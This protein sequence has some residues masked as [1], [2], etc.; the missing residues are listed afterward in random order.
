LSPNVCPH[1]F[2]MFA[3]ADCRDVQPWV[4]GVLVVLA[5]ALLLSL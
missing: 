2:K 4:L 3:M 5:G 1:C